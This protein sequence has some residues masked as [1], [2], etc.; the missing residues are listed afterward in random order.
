MGYVS[1]ARLFSST[2][3]ITKNHIPGPYLSDNVSGYAELVIANIRPT[4]VASENVKP[5]CAAQ[6]PPSHAIINGARKDQFV[7]QARRF[8]LSSIG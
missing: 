2:R 4:R 1:H 6:I 7:A 3:T 5:Y 8:K